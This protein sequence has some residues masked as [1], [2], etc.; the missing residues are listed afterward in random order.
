MEEVKA[1][2][3]REAERERGRSALLHINA[4]IILLPF[5]SLGRWGRTVFEDEENKKYVLSLVLG[6]LM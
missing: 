6:S 4:I 3:K 1:R 5:F 2:P